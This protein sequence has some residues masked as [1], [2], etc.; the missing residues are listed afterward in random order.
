[1][2]RTDTALPRLWLDGLGF[3]APGLPDW[4]SAQAA[5][6][7]RLLAPDT[8]PPARPAPALLAPN[9]RRRAPDGVLLALQVA[10]AAVQAADQDPATLASVFS[11]AH[12]D[13]R[14]VDAL[15][16]TLASNPLLLSPTRFHHSVHNA[17]SGYWALASG[18][19]AP[20]TALAGYD[21]SFALGLLEAASQC[22]ADLCPVLLVGFDTGAQGAL[23][24]VNTS[25]G[26]LGVGLVLAP[27]PG[28]RSLWSLDLALHTAT[29]GAAHG[30][31]PRPLRSAA[32]RALAGNAQADALPLL[33]AL[34]QLSDEAAPGLDSGTP[35]L[36]LALGGG[37][38]LGLQ[39]QRCSPP[40]TPAGAG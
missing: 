31:A 12:G 22:V 10:Q 28:P 14:I 40:A 1:M 5:F 13:L 9:E 25:R 34:A 18:S 3:W 32:A 20:S 29:P 2:P 24:S 35:P 27:Q 33:E 17:A 4:A 11:S 8:P 7:G 16:S 30:A 36:W 6:Q 39:L 15:C 19:H 26:L 21:H 37:S 23:A 38:A